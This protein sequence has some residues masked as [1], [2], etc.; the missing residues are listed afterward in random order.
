MKS[1]HVIQIPICKHRSRHSTTRRIVYSHFSWGQRRVIIEYTGW[2]HRILAKFKI[3]QKST[4]C[5]LVCTLIFRMMGRGMKR[6]KWEKDSY[7]K[8]FP[9]RWPVFTK[10]TLI[11]SMYVLWYTW[12]KLYTNWVLDA[13]NKNIY[14]C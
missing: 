4:P 10:W 6:W 14:R 11:W 7:V 3:R 13:G 8:I 9:L 1:F 5:M 2:C 12:H